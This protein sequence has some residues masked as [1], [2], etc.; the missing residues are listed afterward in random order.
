MYSNNISTISF[1]SSR[2]RGA[3]IE[4]ELL[5]VIRRKYPLA[6][7][8]QGNHKAFDVSIPET[9]DAVE[10]KFDERSDATGN[11]FIETSY[12][13]NPSGIAATKA[14][15]WAL[16]DA[17]HIYWVPPDVLRYIIQERRCRTCRYTG[18]DGTVVESYLLKKTALV[19]SPYVRI[20]EREKLPLDR[21]V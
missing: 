13:G 18:K 6:H 15:W 8:M 9:G 3:A 11:F 2:S 19:H 14:S 10:I 21:S 7:K 20:T 16:V 12:N 5:R 1:F 17:T 4:A